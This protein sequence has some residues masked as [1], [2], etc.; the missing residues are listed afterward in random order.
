MNEWKM[1]DI[2]KLWRNFCGE[3]YFVGCGSD[4]REKCGRFITAHKIMHK[5][6]L[7]S[8]LQKLKP[9]SYLEK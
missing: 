9:D 2:G 4:W 8:Y 6:R 7:G 1:I 3:V 5:L